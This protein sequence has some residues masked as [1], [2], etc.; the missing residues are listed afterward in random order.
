MHDHLGFGPMWDLINSKIRYLK[1]LLSYIKPKYA[2]LCLYITYALFAFDSFFNLEKLQDGDTRHVELV[3]YSLIILVS[4]VN[5]NS[6]MAKI[7]LF[8]PTILVPF[9]MVL[10]KT[11]GTFDI[12]SNTVLSR[13]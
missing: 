9:Y 10:K 11:Q 8:T 6:F 7:I 5:Y 4:A 2:P 3:L 1:S 13:F 12:D